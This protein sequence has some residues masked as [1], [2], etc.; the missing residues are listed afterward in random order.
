MIPTL[1]HL[2]IKMRKSIATFVGSFMSAILQGFLHGITIFIIFITINAF[3]NV[4]GFNLV[5]HLAIKLERLP[6]VGESE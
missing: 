4:N 2:E 1:N 3:L 6:I 5:T